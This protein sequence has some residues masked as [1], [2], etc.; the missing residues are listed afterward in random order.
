[1]YTGALMPNFFFASGVVSF[2]ILVLS[3]WA[4]R[5]WKEEE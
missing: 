4:Y 5:K 3:I 2:I 1:V